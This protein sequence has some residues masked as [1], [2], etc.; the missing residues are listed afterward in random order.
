MK[1]KTVALFCN[2]NS[3][4]MMILYNM[5]MMTL[6]DMAQYILCHFIVCCNIRG[7]DDFVVYP[8]AHRHDNTLWYIIMSMDMMSLHGVS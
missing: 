1:M 2:I 6:H 7:H 8:N 3:M 5:I 4:G